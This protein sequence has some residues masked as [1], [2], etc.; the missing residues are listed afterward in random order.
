MKLVPTSA[1]RPGDHFELV[2]PGCEITPARESLPSFTVGSVSRAGAKLVIAALE[3]YTI[4]LPDTDLVRLI[5][6]E[7]EMAVPTFREFTARDIEKSA[8]Y[9]VRLNIEH[10]TMVLPSTMLGYKVASML[11]GQT[12]LLKMDCPSFKQTFVN[13]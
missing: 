8:D 2:A 13:S 10:I 3:G 12:L 5:T 9:Q 7:D 6:G 4:H 11:T 1:L